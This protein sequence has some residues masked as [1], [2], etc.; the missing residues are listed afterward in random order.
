[1]GDPEG[2]ARSNEAQGPQ[3]CQIPPRGGEGQNELQMRYFSALERTEAP[4]RSLTSL[5]SELEE[6]KTRLAS[7]PKLGKDATC[8]ICLGN[9]R[10]VAFVP[11]AAQLERSA[12]GRDFPRCPICRTEFTRAQPLYYASNGRGGLQRLPV[13]GPRNSKKR[14]ADGL[15]PLEPAHRKQSQ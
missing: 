2:P 1:M 15:R 4:A 9:A 5:E 12:R 14:G 13:R 7:L 8:V 6:V 10:G 3:G 11:C